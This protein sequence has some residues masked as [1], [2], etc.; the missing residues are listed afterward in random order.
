[1]SLTFADTQN[2][3]LRVATPQF[4]A[5]FVMK[6]KNQL[7]GF[8]VSM[9]SQICTMIKRDCKYQIMPF[10]Q[11]IQ[12]VIDNKSDV[13]IGAI[14][15]TA[16][17]AKIVNF[18]IPYMIPNTRFLAK[19]SMAKTPIDLKLLEESKIGI[20]KGSIFSDELKNMGLT[21][22]SINSYK[23]EGAL[24]DALT[25][26]SVDL[27]LV[28][29]STAMYWQSQ[30]DQTLLAVGKPIPYGFGIGV[31]IQPNKPELL[32]R[33]SLS[34][35]SSYLGVTRETLSRIRKRTTQI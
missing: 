8:D 20:I 33:I 19:S 16:D 30:S 25:S 23:N 5:P 31:V 26:G 22:P 28:D 7:Y 3:I 12:S 9:M 35:L 2:Q 29:N 6:G 1:M 18:S 32:Q 17:R 34:Q 11:V 15:I 4:I 13:A 21:N 10:N 24:I 14:T 27:V